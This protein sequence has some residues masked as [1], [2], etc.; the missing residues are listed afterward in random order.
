MRKFQCLLFVWKQLY[1]SYDIICMTLPSMSSC[2]LG[3]SGF[4]FFLLTL[5]RYTTCSRVFIVDFEQLNTHW[6]Y[7]DFCICVY[8]HCNKNLEFLSGF[9]A[10]FLLKQTSN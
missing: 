1:I 6:V 7:S 9:L 8:L 3:C 10:S 5:N 2:Q 4:F